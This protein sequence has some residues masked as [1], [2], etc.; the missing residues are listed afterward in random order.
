MNPSRT[1]R[2]RGESLGELSPDLLRA[3]VGQNVLTVAGDCL[4][5]FTNECPGRS[6][7]AIRDVVV[8]TSTQVAINRTG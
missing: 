1:L 4:S 5:T 7:C 2:L 8:D 6:V 3:V